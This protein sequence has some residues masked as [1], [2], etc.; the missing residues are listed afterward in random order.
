MSHTKKIESLVKQAK[1]ASYSLLTLSTAKKNK[2]LLEL[3]KA[4]LRS[5]KD[6]IA[7]NQKDVVL[8]TSKGLSGAMIDRLI[9]NEKRIKAMSDALLEVASLPDPISQIVETRERQGLQIKR[10]RIPLGV[11]AMIYES[12]PNVTIDAASLCFKSGNAVILRGGSEAFYS[13]QCLVK[14]MQEILQK[15]HIDPAVV[16]FIP[17][18]DRQAMIDLLQ[19]DKDI[20]VVIPRGGESLMQFIKEHSKIPVIKH[21]KGVCSIFVDNSAKV[22]ASLEVIYN[23]KVQRPGVCNALENLYV[24]EKIAAEFLPQL[25]QRLSAAGVEIRGDTV[26]RSV[27]PQMKR[28]VEKDFDTEYLDLIL[29][30]K[31]VK[32]V[33]DAVS[34]IRAHS[35]GHT[36]SILTQN[37]KN[38]TFFVNELD[39]SCVMVNTSTRFNDGGELGLGAEI[40]IS[41]TKLHAYGPMG[42][43]ELTTT[44]FV[45]ES[46]YK[47]RK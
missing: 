35:S 15:H 47:T 7:F 42:L 46:D 5:Q 24:H 16:S 32:N 8:A 14:I 21:D 36:E 33:E 9:L 10:V 41:T 17:F 22:S 29:A 6:I 19:F 44:K 12:R 3:A 40:G 45:V 38:A 34:E 28:A 31:V 39:S 13:N 20:N 4:L 1:K 11:I 23:A 26:A 37:K 27:V 30:V 2:I 25:F 43:N 18:T